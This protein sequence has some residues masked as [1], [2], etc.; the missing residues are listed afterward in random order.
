MFKKVSGAACLDD[1][2]M[3]HKDHLVGDIF[4]KA[5]FV[6]DHQHGHPLIRQ[7]AHDGQHLP[8]QLRVQGG[9]RFIEVDDLRV[10]GDGTGDGHPLL[11]TAGE[12][13]GIVILPIQHP[14]LVQGLA[15]FDDGLGLG[16]LPA[17]DQALSDIF[18]GRPVAEQVVILEHKGRLFS[19]AGN[20][21]FRDTPH[22]KV[23]PVKDHRTV[24][25]ILQEVHTAEQG[26]F[27]GTAGA[28]DSYHIAFFYRQVN[29]S[30]HLQRTKGF[31]NI[32]DFQHGHTSC[33]SYAPSFA[34][35][36]RWSQVSTVENIR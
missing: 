28:D 29:A 12:L 3:L 15:G 23:V 18:Q 27:T 21:L 19:Q 25:G 35:P 24:P 8:G 1:Y 13:V 4:G 31:L 32:S 7:L 16:Y 9:G 33:F 26:G 5:H 14:H 30:Q 10:G 22:V 6:G 11:L 20:F 17:H 34:S 2:A 36:A